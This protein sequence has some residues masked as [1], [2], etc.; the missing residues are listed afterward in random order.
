MKKIKPENY[1]K[2]KKLICDWSNKKNYLIHHRMLK[3]YV[4]HGIIVDKIHEKFSFKQSK[5]LG[6]NIKFNSQEQKKA[7]NEFENSMNYLKTHFMEKQYKM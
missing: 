4:R 7:K 3:F 1:T 6:K 5:W 2:A